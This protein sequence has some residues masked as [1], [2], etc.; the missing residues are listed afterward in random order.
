MNKRRI[1]FELTIDNNAHP[2]TALAPSAVEVMTAVFNGLA[3]AR[4]ATEARVILLEDKALFEG[5]VGKV[6]VGR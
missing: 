1:V 4:L 6:E 3:A 2:A 5:V